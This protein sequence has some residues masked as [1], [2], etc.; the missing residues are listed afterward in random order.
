MRLVD[1][2]ELPFAKFSRALVDALDPR[3]DDRLVRRAL[4]KPA[5]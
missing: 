2:D 3:N 4:V 1:D 5:L